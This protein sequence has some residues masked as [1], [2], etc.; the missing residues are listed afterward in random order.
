MLDSSLGSASSLTY[1]IPE[2]ARD[3]L[4][5]EGATRVFLV[6][7]STGKFVGFK[8]MHGGTSG[9]WHTYYR[10][11]VTGKGRLMIPPAL[12][13]VTG[14]TRGSRMEYIAIERHGLFIKVKRPRTKKIAGTGKKGGRATRAQVIEKKYKT[15]IEI[16]PT[17]RI[18]CTKKE[19][20]QAVVNRVEKLCH[21]VTAYFHKLARTA[22]LLV[23]KGTIKTKEPDVLEKL[24]AHLH[25][26]E[27]IELAAIPHVLEYVKQ[28]EKNEEL[29]PER[30]LE[31]G[32]SRYSVD[33]HLLPLDLVM[34][35]DQLIKLPQSDKEVLSH[36]VKCGAMELGIIGCELKQKRGYVST[37]VRGFLK[38]KTEM[39]S[40]LK[41]GA[42]ISYLRI[43][44]PEKKSRQIKVDI[45][46]R[47]TIEAFETSRTVHGEAAIDN[48]GRVKIPVTI[49]ETLGIKGKTIAHIWQD[50]KT[51]SLQLSMR[52]P[53]TIKA[54]EITIPEAFRIFIPSTFRRA[55]KLV[56]GDRMLFICPIGQTVTIK[57]IRREKNSITG[58]TPSYRAIERQASQD[59]KI[60]SDLE[61]H[62]ECSSH[63]DNMS[64][65]KV[66]KETRGSLLLNILNNMVF[67]A[68]SRIF[69]PSINITTI[70]M[71]QLGLNP[72][73]EI[74]VLFETTGE[75]LK[76]LSKSQENTSL[77]NILDSVLA[78]KGAS[79]KLFLDQIGN[80]AAKK[81]YTNQLKIIALIQ[82]IES[83]NELKLVFAGTY[84]Q[85][86]AKHVV[87][88]IKKDEDNSEFTLNFL[89]YHK[90]KGK[91]DEQ[92]ITI[93]ADMISNTADSDDEVV[94]QLD[95]L[96]DSNGNG[97]NTLA[98][99]LGLT[100]I[101]KH[102][103]ITDST[104]IR[105]TEIANQLAEQV[106]R[107]I[108]KKYPSPLVRHF[109]RLMLENRLTPYDLRLSSVISSSQAVGTLEYADKVLKNVSYFSDVTRP[110]NESTIDILRIY[111]YQDVIG[112]EKPPSLR[113]GTHNRKEVVVHS[114]LYHYLGKLQLMKKKIVNSRDLQVSMR[115]IFRFTIQAYHLKYKSVKRVF[116]MMDA[117][118]NEQELIYRTVNR[119]IQLG[120]DIND[121]RIF[122]ERLG[123]QYT[124]KPKL[125][126]KEVSNIANARKNL[127]ALVNQWSKRQYSGG[128][129]NKQ[130]A[131]VFDLRNNF[132]KNIYIGNY[133]H[134]SINMLVKPLLWLYN[135]GYVPTDSTYGR[136][137]VYN[138]TERV[139]NALPNIMSNNYNISSEYIR[140][141]R[142]NING[143]DK[144]AGEIISELDIAIK[145]LAADSRDNK[146]SKSVYSGTQVERLYAEKLAKALIEIRGD[147]I[148][149]NVIVIDAMNGD[150]FYVSALT[151]EL[152]VV[153]LK[154]TPDVFVK[155]KENGK[156]LPVYHTMH[157]AGL[158]GH[159]I[160]NDIIRLFF[161]CKGYPDAGVRAGKRGK[162]KDNYPLF[163]K[164][165]AKLLPIQK[166]FEEIKVPP[167]GVKENIKC[168]MWFIT[169]IRQYGND[170]DAHFAKNSQLLSTVFH[171]LDVTELAR[172][173]DLV[174]TN[175][176]PE[177]VLDK[178]L[179]NTMSAIIATAYQSMGS[180]YKI[181]IM[182]LSLLPWSKLE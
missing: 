30:F 149:N 50:Q 120:L 14:M 133:G 114:V 1:A 106:I 37:T 155:S 74:E 134:E 40:A 98:S 56:P 136:K 3:L 64:G 76:L 92:V 17:L 170:K 4:E 87:L 84:R 158:E 104:D 132:T 103:M 154:R 70:K 55:L 21:Q 165:N 131:P 48:K 142:M 12:Q 161:M 2:T 164:S 167:E 179:E 93:F 130:D 138:L 9:A 28:K 38:I 81:N 52:K 94:Y 65:K 141:D 128:L 100:Y 44:P 67:T 46:L 95:Q 129:Y 176:F 80:K 139:V 168:E 122:F 5:I 115:V 49:R 63:R 137:L 13:E 126:V 111:Q 153:E 59:G 118:G 16:P 77:Y 61:D 162:L 15:T 116:E 173:A 32:R 8:V 24:A 39:R 18:N 11:T 135:R 62:Q 113:L 85:G 119:L 20:E 6:P 156:G 31:K 86:P 22:A 152:H 112:G 166:L 180:A 54:R 90:L 110:L 53:S 105:I 160:T 157:N 79:L 127:L 172:R 82:K 150:I 33:G 34:D 35:D 43:L 73:S 159:R 147:K 140:L 75:F 45:K 171:I 146:G 29:T 102:R 66:E 97:I 7:H 60:K 51:S 96:T 177:V 175:L 163:S 182:F 89:Y 107:E 47:G 124:P 57:K 151:K 144:T 145:K 25:V 58:R 10:V 117:L 83:N 178:K 123:L 42:I 78:T 125:T 68:P 121:V 99:N 174:A 26:K 27:P 108:R 91:K 181:M 101:I 41:K 23:K 88:S 143:T 71:N 36:L 169:P 148:L 19:L 72:L 69:K 109:K